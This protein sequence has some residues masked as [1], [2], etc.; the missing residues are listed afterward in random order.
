MDNF[1]VSNTSASWCIPGV[2]MNSA[3]VPGKFSMCCVNSQSLCAR[4]MSKFNELK[5]II[6]MTKVDFICVTETWLNSRIDSSIINIDGYNIIRNDRVGRIGGG[7]LIYVKSG[8]NFNVLEL[9][10][11]EIGEV[12]SE[13]IVC[14]ISIHNHK[15]LFGVIYNPPEYDCSEVV[16]TIL[17]RYGAQYESIYLLGD[18]NTNLQ[19]ANALK[20]R[21][22]QEILTT[23]G[24]ES[25]GNEPT[26]FHMNGASQ[27]DLLLCN[28]SSHILRFNQIDI[29]VLSNH[30]MIFASLNIETTQLNSNS[31]QIR[32]YD[33]VNATELSNS[34]DAI[35]WDSFYS[36]TDPDML[37]DIFNSIICDLHDQHVPIRTI[38]KKSNPNPWFT[39]GIARAIVDRDMSF[40]QWKVTRNESDHVLFKRLRNKVNFLVRKAKQDFLTLRINTDLPAKTLWKRL[41]NIGINNSSPIQSNTFEADTINQFFSES[42]SNGDTGFMPHP[43]V[44]QWSTFR[45]HTVDEAQVINSIWDIKSDAVGLDNIPLRFIKMCLPYLI[46]QITHIFNAIIENCR[47]PKCWK[48]SKII[49]IK[50]K[51]VSSSLQNLRP[52]SI[53]CVLSKVLESILK[54]QICE[55]LNENDLLNTFQSGY[56]PKHST[57]TAMMKVFDDIGIALDKGKPVVLVLLDFSKAFDTI[58]HS[59]LCSKLQRN[60]GFSSNAARLVYSYLSER[61][62]SVYNNNT[63]SSFIPILSG[64]PQGSILGPIFFTMY[65]N[66]L[67]NILKHCKIHIY[68][69][70][71]ELYL[72]CSNYSIDSIARYVNEDLSRIFEWSS[73]NKLS[74]NV[75]KTYAM[76][77]T[78]SFYNGNVPSL[79]LNQTPLR[80]V[81]KTTSLGFL[82]KNNLE[83]D[84]YILLQCGKIYSKLRTLQL[85]AHFLSSDIKLK[86]FK[87]LVFP[88]FT[89]CDF[90]LQQISSSTKNKL[91]VAL[92]ACVRY[93]F[94]LGRFDHVTHLQSKLI[95]CPFE[96]FAKLRCCLQIRNIVT[97][98]QP[99]YLH[100]KLS[101]CRSIRF[102]KFTLPRHRTTKYGNSFFVRGVA[103]WNLLPNDLTNETSI[104]RFRKKC[105]EHFNNL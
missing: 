50:K 74:I 87:S 8:F 97:N 51:N 69:D 55:Y 70:D 48:L 12:C 2:V 95:G 47:F 21:R 80:Y 45:F 41:K 77:L 6:L 81:E 56:R 46:S 76:F 104:I 23:H 82:I 65:I 61:R 91:R 89:N 105:F 93:V 79:I 14:E 103:T 94:N 42:F 5:Q 39:N 37:V 57:K 29:P 4:Q 72:D 7:V 17:S 43:E 60:F 100:S 11:S 90:L 32:N 33:R 101:Q 66:D 92:N 64:V 49:P 53:L 85:C 40:K 20:T 26:F 68:A 102:T 67:P 19:N 96:N 88:Y 36:I 84:H 71:V 52:I 63:F 16:D 44:P 30:D 99:R 38:S 73:R 10:Y 18:F 34:L 31:F 86:L 78:T 13:F 62:Q 54:K 3:L 75:E 9:S 15:Q 35:D 22:L 58:S 27:L 98:Q 25:I 59:K 28:D 24:M 1:P 83:W